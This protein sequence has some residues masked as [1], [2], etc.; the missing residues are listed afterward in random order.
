MNPFDD[1]GL[2]K[3]ELRV[4]NF[5]GAFHVDAHQLLDI[6]EKRAMLCLRASCFPEALE[7]T[8]DFERGRFAELQELY[9]ALK[10]NVRN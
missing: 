9:K 4:Q 3:Y 6:I 5:G 2:P 8:T 10:N 7:R 1:P